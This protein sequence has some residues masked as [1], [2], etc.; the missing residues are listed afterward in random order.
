ME[1]TPSSFIGGRAATR[2]GI[3]YYKESDSSV[4]EVYGETYTAGEDEGLPYSMDFVLDERSDGIHVY[5]FVVNHELDADDNYEGGTLKIYRERVEPSG[6][7]TEIYSETFTE[8]TDDEDYPVSVS[9]VIL[10]DD[11]S[12][13]Y[14]VLEYHGEG[15][16]VGKSAL[17]SIAKGGTGSRTVIKTYD[18]PLVGARSP[19]GRDGSYFY[20][21]GGWVRPQKDDLLDTTLPD[22]QNHY[23]NEGGR[24]IEITSA[25]AVTDHGIV[26]Q[27][28]SK[29]DSPNPDDESY[30]GW[31]LYNAV[32]SNMIADDRD[33]LHFVAG[34]GS[35]YNISENLPFSSNQEPAPSF[36]NFNCDSVGQRSINENRIVPN[37]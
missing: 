18:N 25:D 23:P 17:C 8:S 36:S 11:R 9:D 24:L 33:N 10:A 20:L 15:D 30:D 12:K 26:W 21:E 19:V 31:G 35:P 14:F 29:L 2:S 32:I 6:T 5:T 3:A 16:R 13:F 7:Q 34:F 4:N 1:T 22:D 27:S 37:P 28:A